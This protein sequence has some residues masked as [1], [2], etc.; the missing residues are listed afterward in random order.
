MMHMDL[1]VWTKPFQ[2]L[3]DVL[4]EL[5]NVNSQNNLYHE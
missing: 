3:E 2:M 1:P 4:R 5:S